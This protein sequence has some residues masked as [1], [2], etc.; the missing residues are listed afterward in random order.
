MRGKM[1]RLAMP[2]NIVL[3]ACCDGFIAD[4]AMWYV[5]DFSEK[6]FQSLFVV[7][8]TL[9]LVHLASVRINGVESQ[10]I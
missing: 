9:L 2:L 4:E 6:I 10:K 7:E 1:L 8:Y 3:F 5:V